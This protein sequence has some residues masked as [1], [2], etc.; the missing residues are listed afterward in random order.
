MAKAEAAKQQA[1]DPQQRG[2]Q[3]QAAVEG[4]ELVSMSQDPQDVSYCSS[5]G[6]TPLHV[7][8]G[9]FAFCTAPC[10]PGNAGRVRLQLQRGW[11]RG[12]EW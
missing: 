7:A 11:P 6:R 12:W 3:A 9:G 1:A 2:S 10:R 5:A 4:Q 8:F